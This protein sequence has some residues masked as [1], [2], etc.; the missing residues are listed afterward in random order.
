MRQLIYAGG[1][2]VT[3]DAIAESVLRFAAALANSDRAAT[4]RVPA[5]GVGE[6]GEV[7]LLLGPSSQIMSE[8]SD[9]EGP[10]PDGTAF[11]AEV[12]GLVRQHEQRYTLPE[13]N[14]E[15]DWDI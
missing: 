11:I 2:F 6:P 3:S 7:E 4:I 13:S 1:S 5:V 10:E 8:P 9:V 15:F 12:E 14:G